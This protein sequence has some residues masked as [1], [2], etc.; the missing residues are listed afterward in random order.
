MRVPISYALTYPER[1]AT[2]VPPLDLT[3][4]RSSSSSPTPRRS[5]CSRSRARRASAA[6]RTRAPST[7]RTRSPCQAFLDGRIGFL[8]IAALVEDVA[9]ARRRRAGPRPRRAASRPTAAPASWWQ[10]RYGLLA[11][12]VGLAVLLILIHEA[13]HFFAARAVGMTAAEVLPRLRPAA[14]EDDARRRR[15][16]HRRDPAR[17]LRE[18]PGHAPAGAG[19]PAQRACKPEEQRGACRPSS[20]RSTRRSSAATTRQLR[21]AACAELRSPS[22]EASRMLAGARAARSRPTRT[23][24]RR[25]GRRLVV[26]ARRARRRTSSFA[27]RA[28]RRRCS[29]SAPTT[30]RARD[31]HASCRARRPRRAGLRGGRPDPRGRRARRSPPNDDPAHDPRHDGQAVHAR[32][33]AATAGGSSSG[34]LRAKLDQTARYRIGFRSSATGPGESLPAAAG[35]LGRV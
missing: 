15:V 4:D 30:R 8:E 10:A 27:L 14:R 33:R 19:R 22:S 18:D 21:A 13:G 3:A 17:R 11:A 2:P 20:T 31:R 24:A 29:W 34:P 5:G 6:A 16:R 1:A 12:I 25:R 28:L 26:I 35:E 7:P 23:G 32:R 9:R